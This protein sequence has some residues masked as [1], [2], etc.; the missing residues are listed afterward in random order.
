LHALQPALDQL[1]S[2]MVYT[3]PMH[4]AFLLVGNSRTSLQTVVNHRDRHA[5]FS[6]ERKSEAFL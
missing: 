3:S 6:C 4:T 2:G 5:K 1:T